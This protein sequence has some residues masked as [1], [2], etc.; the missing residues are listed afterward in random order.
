MP[1]NLLLLP[2]LGGFLFL[3]IFIP[4][5]PFL[6]RQEGYHLLIYSSL[7]GLA[8]LI[9]ALFLS[10]WRIEQID[11]FRIWWQTH[12]PFD[13]SGVALTALLLG[14]ISPLALNVIFYFA[15]PKG[16][17]KK[18]AMIRYRDRMEIIFDKSVSEVKE[19]AITLKN[20]KVYIGLITMYPEPHI[21]GQR[22]VSILPYFSGYRDQTTKQLIITTNYLLVYD[23]LETLAKKDPELD[24]A[25]FDIVIPVSEIMS[26]SIYNQTVSD[27]FD[28]IAVSIPKRGARRTS[29]K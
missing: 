9:I 28:D 24:V 2:L 19:V 25:D 3:R 15:F 29:R 18:A 20:N 16:F 17:F 7:S 10:T 23:Q 1:F 4:T 21:R 5:K 27:I 22:F 14:M 26:I 12:V 8:L 13:Y 6:L 11:S